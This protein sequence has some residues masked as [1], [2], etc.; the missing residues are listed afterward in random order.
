MRSALDY[1]AIQPEVVGGFMARD[2]ET[3][4]AL[5]KASY[6]NPILM[7][8]AIAPVPWRD[9]LYF[10]QRPL[11]VGYFK[12]D[13]VW[14]AH[15]GN[16]RA[17]EEAIEALERKGHTVKEVEPPPVKEL[18]EISL[19]F[20]AGDAGAGVLNTLNK[21]LP[22]D[23][24]SNLVLQAAAYPMHYLPLFLQ[25]ALRYV[26]KFVTKMPYVGKLTECCNHEK[27][28]FLKCFHSSSNWKRM[29]NDR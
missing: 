20:T 17:V 27:F 6:N 1:E 8:P 23:Y 15:P 16:V 5:H 11:R 24:G 12:R 3:L 19:A 25:R 26:A 10:D 9:Q 28:N 29:H 7:D 2:I 13:K 18:V 21:D 22:D 4:T 14:E